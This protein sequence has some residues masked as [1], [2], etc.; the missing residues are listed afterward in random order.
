MLDVFSWLG[1]PPWPGIER[2]V[3]ICQRLYSMYVGNTNQNLKLLILKLLIL[4][5]VVATIT[6]QLSLSKY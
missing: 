6:I 4:I 3:F 2:R 5:D 1:E